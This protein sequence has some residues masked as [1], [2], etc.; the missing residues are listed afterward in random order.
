MHRGSMIILI[1]S[2]IVHAFVRLVLE[3]PFKDD[4]HLVA[5]ERETERGT[6]TPLD[7]NELVNSTREVENASIR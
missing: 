6:V 4:Y 7:Q 3:A 5:L 2:C 1:I